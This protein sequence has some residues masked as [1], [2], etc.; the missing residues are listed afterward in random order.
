MAAPTA[1]DWAALA[2]LARYL[3]VRPRCVYHSPW[4]DDGV[5]LRAYVDTDFAGC[6]RA[7]RSTSG[8]VCMRGLH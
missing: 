1:T 3:I 4:Q 7:R 8:G 5:P 6:L 2:R